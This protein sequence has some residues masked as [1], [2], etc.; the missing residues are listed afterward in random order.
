M[1]SNSSSLIPSTGTISVTCGFPLVIVPVLSKAMICV[2]PVS[3]KDTAVLNI[4]PCFAPIPFPTMIATGVASPKAQ[5]QL[6]T[7]TE[8]PLASANPKLCPTSSQMIIVAIA[9]QITVGTKIPDTLSA[10]FAI[11]ALVAAASLTI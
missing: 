5:G 3:S 4:I 7:N 9:I 10:T 2:F 6:I 1:E 8:I 11:G